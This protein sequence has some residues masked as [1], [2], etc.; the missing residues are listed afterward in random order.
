WDVYLQEI[1]DNRDEYIAYY[2]THAT[3]RTILKAIFDFM[4]PPYRPNLR[5]QHDLELLDYVLRGKWE[6]GDFIWPQVW[7]PA[8][9]QDPYWWLYG[10]PA[11]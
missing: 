1:T 5:A 9:P 3:D 2:N 11:D 4:Q 7:Q 10:R 6:A 8:Y